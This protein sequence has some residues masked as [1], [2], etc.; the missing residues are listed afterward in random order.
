MPAVASVRWLAVCLMD[1]YV[2]ASEFQS[3][4]PSH[5][6]PS[7][8]YPGRQVHKKLPTELVHVAAELQPPLS[9]SHSSISK[10]S[11]VKME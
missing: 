10:T 6:N 7:P 4:L 9:V 8:M 5:V 3:D 11:P 2:K 1:G